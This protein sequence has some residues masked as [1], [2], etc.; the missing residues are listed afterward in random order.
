M[1]IAIIS[2]I[3]S[4]FFYLK[5]VF[6]VLE[7]LKIKRVYCLGDLVGYYDEPERVIEFLMSKKIVTLKGNHE[8]YLLEEAEYPREKE[9]IYRIQYQRKLL[10]KKSIHFLKNLKESILFTVNE[11]KFLMTHSMIGD[12][13]H[14]CYDWRELAKH[15]RGDCD[16]FVTGHTHLPGIIY[17]DG[18][19]LINPGSAGQPRD[20]T[21]KP[22]FAYIN[23]KTMTS[24]IVKVCV[25][26]NHYVDRLN[27]LGIPD[28]LSSILTRNKCYE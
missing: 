3:H 21:S 6:Q 9:Y 10:S 11:K 16:V 28:E 22:S 5:Y 14:Y 25:P 15:I 27:Q 24:S 23:T 2:D 13:I 18:I 12:P 7:S 1:K 4:N 17:T 8:K 19:E 20:Y 26:V